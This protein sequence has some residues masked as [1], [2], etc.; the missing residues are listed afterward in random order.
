MNEIRFDTDL[1]ERYGGR[2]PRYTSYPTA[3]QF[4]QGFGETEYRRQCAASNE[5]PDRRPLS[6]YVHLPFCESLC[7]YCACNKEVTRNRARGERYMTHLYIELD[8]QAT[9]F[10]DERVVEQLHLGGG[11]PTYF[12]TDELGELIRRIGERFR[13]Q[14]DG[15]QEFSIEVDPRTISPEGMAPLNELGFNRLS[16]GVQD[17]EARVQEA[18]NRVQSFEKTRD[19]IDAARASGFQ[20]VSLDLIYGL[21]HQTVASFDATI[22]RVLS[23]RPDRLAI[24]NYAHLPEMFKAQRLIDAADLPDASEKLEILHGTISKLTDAGYEYIGMDHFALPADELVLAQ[25]KGELQRN[26]QGY[27][28]HARC[29]LISLGVSAISHVHH[30]YS[31]NVKSVNRYCQL[32][33]QGRLPVERGLELSDDDELRATV[34]ETIMCHGRLQFGEVERQF[35]IDFDKYFADEV[36]ALG[37][38]ERDGLVR[39]G[40]GGLEVTPAGRLL[41]RPVAM[42]FDRY[43]REQASKTRFSK[44]I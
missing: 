15:N 8:M 27:S 24:Y 23:L 18:V 16:L 7:Y 43:L 11:S 6:I 37:P 44:V 33:E 36:E 32:L 3:V 21:P 22:E 34:I 38:L 14:A 10:D 17:L 30:C 40:P 42:V 1:I 35:G 26:F 9:L 28:T 2:G 4:H 41:L 12:S 20:S 19:L 29:D 39:L 25:R 31:Q 5:G 13:L